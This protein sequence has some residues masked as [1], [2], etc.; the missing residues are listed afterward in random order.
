LRQQRS[1]AASFPSW[2]YLLWAKKGH[3]TEER[4]AA[5]LSIYQATTM[6][7]RKLMLKART[8]MFRPSAAATAKSIRRPA[9]YGKRALGLDGEQRQFVPPEDWHE[10]SNAQGN[11]RIVVQP[12]GKG[13]RHVLTPDDV[14]GRLAELPR[15]FTEPLDVVQFSRITRKKQSFPCYGMQWGT[16][17]YLYP[18]EEELVEYF[19]Q[20]PKPQQINEARMFGGRWVQ[21]KTL[22]RLQWS[23][24]AIRDFYLN[25]ILI[26][27]LGHL[28]DERNNGFADRERF[29]EWFA[30]HYGYRASGGN[31]R[32]RQGEK[33]LRR[34]H[35]K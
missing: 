22:W 31:A 5:L 6:R 4:R 33:I 18:I 27:E 35:A 30:V 17:I 9:A 11:Y 14:R 25:N 34:H 13:Y 29:A 19:P 26:H 2:I 3:P 28:L 23:E 21:E 32:R 24:A 15:Q 7:T 20:P 12:P 10:P 16:A 1:S 8:D